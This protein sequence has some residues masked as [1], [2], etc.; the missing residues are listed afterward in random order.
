[1]PAPSP[2]G[3]AASP[4]ATGMEIGFKPPDELLASK[5]SA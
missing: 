5:A 2:A 3:A 4:M 1:M